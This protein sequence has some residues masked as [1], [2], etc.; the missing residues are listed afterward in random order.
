[1]WILLGSELQLGVSLFSFADLLLDGDELMLLIIY[2]GD[3]ECAWEQTSVI[4]SSKN[5]NAWTIRRNVRRSSPRFRT[6]PT[7]FRSTQDLWGLHV[8]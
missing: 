8:L 2:L 5:S 1:M 3:N 4:R 6:S 7:R